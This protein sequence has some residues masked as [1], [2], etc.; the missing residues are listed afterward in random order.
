MAQNGMYS[1]DFEDEAAKPRKKRQRH[2]DALIIILFV[3]GLAGLIIGFTSKSTLLMIVGAVLLVVGVVK[4]M[5]PAA[6]VGGTA[7]VWECD[8]CGWVFEMPAKRGAHTVHCT[9]PHCKRDVT[10]TRIERG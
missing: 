7:Q 3:V 1:D 6:P 10:C 8:E 9:C 2:G 4:L 5:R